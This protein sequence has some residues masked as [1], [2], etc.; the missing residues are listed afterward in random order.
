[1]AEDASFVI[2]SLEEMNAGKVET[3]FKG[4]LDLEKIGV[5]GHS[6]GGAVAY[7]LAINDER[8]KAAIDLDG[9]VY[10]QPKENANDIAPFLMLASDGYHI[11]TVQN[12]EPLLK[13]FEEMDDIDQKIT[14][15]IYGSKEAY[16]DAYNKAQQNVIGLTE[17]LQAKEGL[18]TI[19]GS[20]HMKFTDIGLFIA[21]PQLR[22]MIG[23]RG[24]T[25]PARCLEITE[26]VTLA[27]FDQYLKGDASGL[28][29]S[30]SETYPELEHIVLK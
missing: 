6:V 21:I 30:L 19:E 7:N 20:D 28:L 25:D 16:Q 18:Y 26:A 11:Q 10:I 3:I 24:E 13:R 2:D 8:V 1:M 4:K 12:R 23:I 29:E 9:V 27:F 22:E 15:D 14:V 17:V 5:I